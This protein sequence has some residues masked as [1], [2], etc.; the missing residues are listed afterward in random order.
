MNPIVQGILAAGVL[1]LIGMGGFALVYG[2]PQAAP[3]VSTLDRLTSANDAAQERLCRANL[4]RPLSEMTEAG[5][6][7]RLRCLARK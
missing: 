4:S 6:A 3:E 1:V 2:V 5:R 7:E